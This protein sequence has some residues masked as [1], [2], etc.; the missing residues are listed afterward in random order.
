MN[1]RRS[2]NKE[3]AHALLESIEAECWRQAYNNASTL[4]PVSVHNRAGATVLCAPQIDILAYNRVIGLGVH[5]QATKRDI[6]DIIRLYRDAGAARFFV[7]VAPTLHQSDMSELLLDAGFE[8][9]NTWVKL[10]HEPDRE[11]AYHDVHEVQIIG[12]DKRALFSDILVEAFDW[13]QHVGTLLS[14]SVGAAGWTHYVIHHKGEA[15]ACAALHCSHGTANLTIAASRPAFRSLGLQQA[16]IRRRISDAARAGATRITAE[17]GSD[18]PTQPSPSFRN[19]R[20]A[21]FI[22]AY[23][24]INWLFPCT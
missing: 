3:A 22:Q 19:L 9:Y 23:E 18:T 21:G 5:E 11:A 14:A 15:A 8:R 13:P 24:R 1:S 2:H 17:T 7:Q 20:R 4:A 12:S 16:L 6:D 10:Y